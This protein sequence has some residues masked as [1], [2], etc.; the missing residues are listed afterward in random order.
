MSTLHYLPIPFESENQFARSREAL[1]RRGAQKRTRLACSMKTLMSF[2]MAALV[3]LPFGASAAHIT[4]VVD[5]NGFTNA[6]FGPNSA[7]PTLTGTFKTGDSVLVALTNNTGSNIFASSYTLPPL[8]SSVLGSGVTNF[9]FSDRVVTYC[10]YGIVKGKA[11]NPANFPKYLNG[12]DYVITEIN[13][14]N[15]TNGFVYNN[16]SLTG[17]FTITVTTD[18]PGIAYLFVDTR[19][20]VTNSN[21]QSLSSGFLPP[22]PLY[23]LDISAFGGPFTYQPGRWLID[24]GWQLVN[25]GYIPPDFVGTNDCVGISSSTGTPNVDTANV[26]NYMA[27]YALKITGSGPQT[28][29]VSNFVSTANNNEYGIA[30]GPTN[31]PITVLAGANQ[32]L[33]LGSNSVTANLHGSVAAVLGTSSPTALWTSSGPAPVTFGSATNPVTTATFTAAG[34][35]TLTLTGNDGVNAPVTSSI[36]VQV[37]PISQGSLKPLT[38]PSDIDTNGILKYAINVGGPGG[39]IVGGA[40][41]TADTDNSGVHQ[42]TDG[43]PGVP[44]TWVSSQTAGWYPAW[45]QVNG[46]TGNNPPVNDTNLA[47]L[48]RYSRNDSSSPRIGQL[49][50]TPGH[51][52]ELQLLFW[53]GDITHD[54]RFVLSVGSGT[55]DTDHGVLNNWEA[56]N[57]AVSELNETTN[58]VVY[59]QILTPT[60]S[61][62]WIAAYPA[63]TNA[64]FDKNP[65]VG[66][67]ILR[68]VSP[69]IL[70]PVVS[71]GANQS[72]S[73]TPS[74]PVTANLT[75]SV[76]DTNLFT[77]TNISTTELWTSSGPAP[78]TFGNATSP[79][80]TAKFTAAGTYTLTLTANN[81]VTPP[82]SSSVTITVI[83]INFGT[84]STVSGPGDLDL[85]GYFAYAIDV[86]GSGGET[87][88]GV[89]FTGDNSNSSGSGNQTQNDSAPGTWAAPGTPGWYPGLNNGGNSAYSLSSD[90]GLNSILST[91]RSDSSSPRISQLNILAGHSYELQIL[92]YGGD[93]SHDRRFS[94]SVGM[95]NGSSGDTA[96]LA[97]QSNNLAIPELNETA[98]PKVFTY[99][100]TAT[101]NKLWIAAYPAVTSGSFDH[102][103]VINAIMLKDLSP[104]DHPPIVN[105]GPSQS[106]F[107]GNGVAV[108]QLAGI[109]SDDYGA[110]SLWSVDPGAPGSVVFGD[111]TSP[112]TTATFT[113]SGSYTLRLTGND[114]TNAPVSSTVTIFINFGTYGDLGP[115]YLDLTGS[116]AYAIDLNGPGGE[117]LGGVTF[118]ADNTNSSVSGN[119]NQNN[120]APGS[121]MSPLTPGWYPS[122]NNLD[123]LSH[124]SF[125]DPTG[126]DIVMSTGREDSASPR[127]SQLDIQAGHTYELQILAFGGDIGHP[128]VF[129]LSVGMGTNGLSGNN[130]ALLAWQ[131][132]NLVVADFDETYP[133]LYTYQFTATTNELWIAAYPD[134]NAPGGVDPNP[135]I[136]AIMLKDLSAPPSLSVTRNVDGT[137][138]ITSPDGTLQS[139]DN[140]NGPYTSLSVQ[141]IT[142]D[143]RTAGPRKFYRALK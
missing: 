113:N 41:F 117:T 70:P 128:R 114:H 120:N 12:L 55:S 46:V 129:S 28:F 87:V 112:T 127:I 32:T 48:L 105:A 108:I 43:S 135:V 62:L 130:N 109:V 58:P 122:L 36:T 94:L 125:G 51:T 98:N 140:A 10:G 131:A 75:G 90:A 143:P 115:S 42:N 139:A 86:N 22:N 15:D 118:T 111:P 20:G 93:P 23:N 38:S 141:T 26:N 72:L 79:T 121:W 67:I 29:T 138:T 1:N 65:N 110:T 142:V 40:T 19:T 124:Y 82:V 96:L 77:G 85:T 106:M 59:S 18:G 37:N 13:N 49:D 76:V 89:P 35:Y 17:G 30:F 88:G 25:T 107:I 33:G 64:S 39:E 52:Y 14:R 137:L 71:A 53:G 8:G 78:V 132:A 91:G 60:S 134:V 50:V 5:S 68:D 21:G 57:I 74:G 84:L 119:V 99:Q 56:A 92:A 27:V 9:A 6:V 80:T 123:N 100:F 66:P 63:S 83:S 73:L 126:L 116:F 133:K 3:A 102:N 81:G 54:R 104:V 2:F 24:Q 11:R 95:G 4:S 101:T 31:P 45:N 34:T 16:G 44:G 103:P 47:I 69:A 61:K 97:W 136:E 7:N